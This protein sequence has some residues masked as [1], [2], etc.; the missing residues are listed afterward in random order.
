TANWR[1]DE[2]VQP[3]DVARVTD[4]FFDV[5]GI[6]L[7]AGRPIQSRE[8]DAVV[9]SDHFWKDRLGRDPQVLGRRLALDNRV[10][11][12]TGVLPPTHRTVAVFGMPVDVYLPVPSDN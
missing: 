6:P 5:T 4:H 12:I 7:A 1:H 9:V 3:L 11:T 2:N 10:Y 8:T